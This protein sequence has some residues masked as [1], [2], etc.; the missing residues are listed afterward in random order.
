MVFFHIDAHRTIFLPNLPKGH[1]Q[2]CFHVWIPTI[3]FSVLK[4]KHKTTWKTHV[5][6]KPKRQQT[7][8][9]ARGGPPTKWLRQLDVNKIEKIVQSNQH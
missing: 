4:T 9:G 2:Q 3:R 8:T 5:N 6:P 7:N 1:G